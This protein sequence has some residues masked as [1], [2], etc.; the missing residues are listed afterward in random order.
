MPL[1]ITIAHKLTRRLADLRK[2]GE[3]K[4][5]GPDGKS[6]V[7]VE[8]HDGVPKRISAVVI[9]AQHSESKPE[10]ELKREI[11]EKVIKP[12]CGSYFDGNTRVHINATGKFVIGGTGRR[13]GTDGQED[14]R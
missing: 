6:Q 3:I 5:L 14:H 8:Y 10:D 1:P 12:V 7:S 9:A 11:L 13:H 2:L 4:G